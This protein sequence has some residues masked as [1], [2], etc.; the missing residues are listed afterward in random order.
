MCLAEAMDAAA[1]VT[2]RGG[3]EDF[4]NP[5]RADESEGK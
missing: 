2:K 1:R 3:R 4:V 5:E